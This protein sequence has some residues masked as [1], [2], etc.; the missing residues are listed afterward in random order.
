MTHISSLGSLRLGILIVSSVCC[1]AARSSGQESANAD[2]T[3]LI[4]A[5]PASTTVSPGGKIKLEVTI[6]NNTDADQTFD[7]PSYAWW[8]HSDNPSVI[9]PT[10]NKLAGLGPVVIFKPVTVAPG[11]AYTNSWTAAIAAAASPGNLIF[12]MGFPLHRVQRNDYYWSSDIKLDV[13]T[14]K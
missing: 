9:F 2:K 14:G 8:A 13:E 3:W 10:W 1:I 6:K 4:E 11:Q 7:L 12:H 5:T